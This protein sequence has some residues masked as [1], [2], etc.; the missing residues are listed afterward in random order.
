MIGYIYTIPKMEQYVTLN[1]HQWNGEFFAFAF[2]PLYK[3]QICEEKMHLISFDRGLLCGV[4]IHEINNEIS[5]ENEYYQIWVH[6]N[7]QF[8]D[9]REQDA[10]ELTTI[11]IGGQNPVQKSFIKLE[12]PW[13]F[14]RLLGQKDKNGSGLIFTHLPNQEIKALIMSMPVRQAAKYKFSLSL[15]PQL[16]GLRYMFYYYFY[17]TSIIFTIGITFS[18]IFTYEIL[19]NKNVWILI[20]S[21]IQ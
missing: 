1:T 3:T 11:V 18:I 10:I 6:I 21:L 14:Q 19:L 13:W 9:Q 15:I 4:I 7:S 8:F 12:Y 16:T 17:T 2:D 20:K 5:F